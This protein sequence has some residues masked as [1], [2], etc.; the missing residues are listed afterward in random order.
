MKKGILHARIPTFFA[1]LFLLGGMFVTIAIV[2]RQVITTGRAS[3]ESVPKNIRITNVTDSSFSITFTTAAPAEA[4]V[5]VVTNTSQQTI[6][7]DDRD[8]ES[9]EQQKRTTHSITLTGLASHKTVTFELLVGSKKYDDNGKTFQATTGSELTTSPPQ[10]IPVFGKIL[11]PDNAPA[12]GALVYLSTEGSQLVSAH[13]NQRGEFLIPLNSLRTADFDNYVTLNSESVLTLNAVSSNLSSDIVI[14]YK[15]AENTP[16]I[17][18]SNSYEF[19]SDFLP[20]EIPDQSLQEASLFSPSGNVEIFV[21]ED[22]EAFVDQQPLFQG[23]GAKSSQ[24]QLLLQGASSLSESITTDINGSWSFRPPQ[25]LIP[26]QYA[27]RVS[28]RSQSGINQVATSSFTIYT[29]GSQIAQFSGPTSTPEPTQ[30]ASPTPT[31]L[32][33]NTPT[34]TVFDAPT[35]TPTETPTPTLLPPTPTEIITITPTIPPTEPPPSKTPDVGFTQ[36][37]FLTIVSG[38]VILT[39]IS[40]LFLF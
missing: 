3:Q 16:P 24:V 27:L 4:A 37:G 31:P 33:T 10:Y 22:G 6:I 30:K 18:L 28:G 1:L 36:S 12:I 38:F 23:G 15:N 14:L 7:I 32:P 39:G 13:T 17:I 8:K 9:G 29:P 26:G 40:L 11:M 19:T 25:Q 34:P 21:P 20:Q 2:Q 5:A 35:P